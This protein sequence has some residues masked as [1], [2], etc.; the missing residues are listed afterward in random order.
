M[1]KEGDTVYILYDTLD[2]DFYQL[3]G[4]VEKV[5]T[6]PS[7]PRGRCRSYK[8][9]L[10]NGQYDFPRHTMHVGLRDRQ[11]VKKAPH[12]MRCRDGHIKDVP[13][14]VDHVYT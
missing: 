9:R 6:S 13:L 8:V 2:F 10:D 4:T 3:K 14:S 11:I 7:Y 5:K 12:Q 1:I